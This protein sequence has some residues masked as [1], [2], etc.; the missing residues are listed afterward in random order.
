MDT[1]ST[2]FFSGLGYLAYAFSKADGKVQTV[3]TS[4]FG[5]VIQR[6]FGQ[7]HREELRLTTKVYFDCL[8][9]GMSSRDAY[10]MAIRLLKEV[11]PMFHQYRDQLAQMVKEISESDNHFSLEERTLLVQFI[12]ETCTM[13]VNYEERQRVRTMHIV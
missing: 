3:E 7:T 10:R 1:S 4:T 9:G 11:Y 12:G 6:L 2:T 5:I 8:Q 13:K